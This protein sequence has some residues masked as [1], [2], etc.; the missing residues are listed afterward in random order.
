[1]SCKG[2]EEVKKQ[3]LSY[4]S[5]QM[6]GSTKNNYSTDCYMKPLD[7]INKAFNGSK[8]PKTFLDF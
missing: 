5:T 8:L 7:N 2:R 4:V 3:S 6:K 1:M